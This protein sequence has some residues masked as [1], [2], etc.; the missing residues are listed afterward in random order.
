MPIADIIP[1]RSR[2]NSAIL[3]SR[4]PLDRIL[5]PA[6]ASSIGAAPSA[7]T[8]A[9]MP[10]LKASASSFVM[11]TVVCSPII[12]D[13]RSIA[14]F[15]VPTNMAAI[16]SVTKPISLCPSIAS[17]EPNPDRLLP[18]FVIFL[19]SVLIAVPVDS[20]FPMRLIRPRPRALTAPISPP[21]IALPSFSRAE[22]AAT[23]SF[24]SPFASASTT[25]PAMAPD[26]ASA[27]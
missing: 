23:A 26:T 17:C 10:S 22:P 2:T 6:V 14:A 4:I 13:S 15:V 19:P 12:W 1:A 11:P 24:R 8:S 5:Y 7:G 16:G 3:V 18:E 20:T 9:I 21:P 25:F 27:L